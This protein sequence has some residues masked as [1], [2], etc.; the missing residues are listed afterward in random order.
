MKK[1]NEY[2]K[3][4]KKLNDEYNKKINKI[5]KL[6]NSLKGMDIENKKFNIHLNNI[7]NEL[8]ENDLE[9][10]IRKRNKSISYKKLKIKKDNNDDN[11]NL[12]RNQMGAFFYYII[13]KK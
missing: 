8:I 7:Q 6:I 11:N 9:N 3:N 5:K 2:K 4:Q 13:N 12:I 10:Y 1:I